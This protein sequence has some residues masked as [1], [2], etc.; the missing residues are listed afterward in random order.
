MND[1]SD[2]VYRTP[3]AEL[4]GQSKPRL[5]VTRLLDEQNGV[6]ATLAAA[7]AAVVTALSWDWLDRVNPLASPLFFALSGVVVGMASRYGGRGLSTPVYLS[8]VAMHWL[9]VGLAVAIFRVRIVDATPAVILIGLFLAGS[10][11]AYR[12]S[13]RPLTGEQN[14]ILWREDHQVGLPAPRMRNT[15]WAVA[16]TALVCVVAGTIVTAFLAVA[17]PILLM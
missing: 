11:A 9:C 7:I 3:D 6:T 13:R 16:M 5:T 14:S 4:G 17:L 10:V 15:W 2:D 8:A 12:L 1:A